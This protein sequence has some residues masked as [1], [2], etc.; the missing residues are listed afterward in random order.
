MF[1]ANRYCG[2]VEFAAGVWVGVELDTADGK[3]DGIIQDTLYF[4]CSPNHGTSSS[5]ISFVLSCYGC[6]FQ[7]L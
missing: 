2:T 4:K 5:T 3:N 1:C 6:L 7:L